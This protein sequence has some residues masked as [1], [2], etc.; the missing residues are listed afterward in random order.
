MKQR[1]VLPGILF[2]VYTLVMLWLLFG[3]RISADLYTAPYADQLESAPFPFQTI[4]QFVRIILTGEPIHLIPHAWQNLIGN[5]VMF[6]PLGWFLPRLFPCCRSLRR[7]FPIGF[8]IIACVELTQ[9]FTLLGS[10]D[11]DDFML[12]S[13]GVVLGFTLWQTLDSFLKA[14]RSEQKQG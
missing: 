4:V 8:L 3:Q 2:G 11:F 7:T 6:I 1:K 5:V 10:L 9:F 12:N 13:I 14:R